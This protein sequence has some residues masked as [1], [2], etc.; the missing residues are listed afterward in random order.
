VGRLP[1]HRVGSTPWSLCDFRL[2]QHQRDPAVQ[3]MDARRKL[4]DPM[5]FGS[6]QLAAEIE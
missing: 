3:V 4:Q 6:T 2:Q 1:D 5:Q